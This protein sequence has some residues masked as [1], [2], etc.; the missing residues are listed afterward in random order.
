MYRVR[1]VRARCVM[2]A[3]SWMGCVVVCVRHSL[4]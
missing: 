1:T 2:H 4:S 3:G